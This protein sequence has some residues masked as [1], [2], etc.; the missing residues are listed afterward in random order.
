LKGVLR[1]LFLAQPVFSETEIV[2]G[3]VVARILR[4]GAFKID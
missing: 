4:K 2:I 3:A 1:S